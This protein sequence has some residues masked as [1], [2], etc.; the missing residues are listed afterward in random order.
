[1]IPASRIVRID[2]AGTAALVLATALA[3]AVTSGWTGAVNFGV[4]GVLFLGGCLAFAVGFLR[5]VGRSRNEQIDLAGLFYLTGAAPP[6][7]RRAM[8]GLWFAQIAAATVSIFTVSPPWGVMAPVWGIGLLTLWSGRH[9]R[10]PER[11]PAG[12]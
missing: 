2:A 5:A 3:S 1:V 4:S 7:V 10:F 9:G 8:L 12:R 11:A 6:D